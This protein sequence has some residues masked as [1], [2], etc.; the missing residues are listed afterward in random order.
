[1][2]IWDEQQKVDRQLN[3]QIAPASPPANP[4]QVTILPND[5]QPR[6]QKILRPLQTRKTFV[7]MA[8]RFKK[9]KKW[10]II[11]A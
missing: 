8:N 11:K 7:S 6:V 5:N 2:S 10:F 3:Q 1:M 4:K 9:G